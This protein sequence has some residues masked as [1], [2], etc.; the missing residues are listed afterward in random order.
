MQSSVICTDSA[1]RVIVGFILFDT[2][3]AHQ[4]RFHVQS[5]VPL[6]KTCL[7]TDIC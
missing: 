3:T 5:I 7:G 4:L 6:N 2:Y 1:D